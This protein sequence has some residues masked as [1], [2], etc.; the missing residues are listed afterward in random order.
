MP[1]N[2]A[3]RTWVAFSES[4]AS[5]DSRASTSTANVMK[6]TAEA[7]P[8]ARMIATQSLPWAGRSGFGVGVLVSL[9]TLGLVPSDVATADEPDERTDEDRQNLALDFQQR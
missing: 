7:S 4:P 1:P 5:S 2:A 8:M 3:T 9:L 6:L